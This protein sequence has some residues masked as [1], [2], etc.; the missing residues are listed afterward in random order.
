MSTTVSNL[1]RVRLYH[2]TF[3]SEVSIVTH[4]VI[5]G[6]DYG[7][8]Q[9][10]HDDSGYRLVAFNDEGLKLNELLLSPTIPQLKLKLRAEAVKLAKFADKFDTDDWLSVNEQFDIKQS[11]IESLLK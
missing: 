4:D 9:L 2:H 1:A 10:V 6:M 7:W 8:I 11:Q 3:H 5:M